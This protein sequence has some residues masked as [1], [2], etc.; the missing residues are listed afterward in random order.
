MRCLRYLFRECSAKLLC[1]TR[2]RLVCWELHVQ[3][4]VT[5]FIIAVDCSDFGYVCFALF[6][7]VVEDFR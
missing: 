4:K 6:E 7:N 2:K 3:C 1:H 5:C